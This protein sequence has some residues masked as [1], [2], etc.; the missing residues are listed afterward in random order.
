MDAICL[1]GE[2]DVDAV[3]DDERDGVFSADGFG[4]TGDRKELR[5]NTSIRISFIEFRMGDVYTSSVSVFFSR[6]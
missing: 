5:G 6:T 4:G 3:V 1:N 2:G